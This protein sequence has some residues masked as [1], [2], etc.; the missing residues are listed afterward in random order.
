MMTEKQE[1][2]FEKF[3]KGMYAGKSMNG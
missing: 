2:D 1:F 3:N